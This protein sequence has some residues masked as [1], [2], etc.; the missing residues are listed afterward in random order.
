MSWRGW[1]IIFSEPETPWNEETD[2]NKNPVKQLYNLITNA[3]SP[4]DEKHVKTEADL[5]PLYAWWEESTP[6][7]QHVRYCAKTRHG[8]SARIR[9]C[10]PH[11]PTRN[12]TPHFPRSVLGHI[13]SSVCSSL[14]GCVQNRSDVL[15]ITTSPVL[16]VKLG[17]LLSQELLHGA[18]LIHFLFASRV[19]VSI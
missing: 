13:T 6:R 8:T 1:R 5:N 12:E 3:G 17:F 4:G 11:L 16:L 15:K 2:E 10:L 14:C 18:L 9:P 19:T 7:H